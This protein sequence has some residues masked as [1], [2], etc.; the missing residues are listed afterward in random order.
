MT[1]Q[2]RSEK[3]HAGH[4]FDEAKAVQITLT[5]GS[6]QDCAYPAIS[7]SFM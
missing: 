3:L 4:Y 1:F 2:A 5:E 6:Q 7:R